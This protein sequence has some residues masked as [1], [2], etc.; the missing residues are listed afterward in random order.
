[1]AMKAVIDLIFIVKKSSAIDPAIM[2]WINHYYYYYL[3]INHQS[4]LTTFTKLI[5]NLS[6][7]LSLFQFVFYRCC[8]QVIILNLVVL[9]AQKLFGL[10]FIYHHLEKVIIYFNQSCHLDQKEAKFI[11]CLP[12]L[13]SNLLFIII[14]NCQGDQFSIYH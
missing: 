13:F 11:I 9:T 7:C 8:S 4:F 5:I 14:I 6:F 10:L 1:M 2:V 12:L 3:F